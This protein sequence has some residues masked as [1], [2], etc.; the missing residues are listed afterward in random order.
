MADY[1]DAMFLQTMICLISR[2]SGSFPD[3]YQLY[4][5]FQAA[6]LN[7]FGITVTSFGISAFGIPGYTLMFWGYVDPNSKT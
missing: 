1:S 5:A 6:A 7:Q 2:M 3:T 4:P